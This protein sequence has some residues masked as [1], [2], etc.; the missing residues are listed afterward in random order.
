MIIYGDTARIAA[1]AFR[2]L[3]GIQSRLDPGQAPFVFVN[4]NN[5]RGGFFSCGL[6]K[7]Q[8]FCFS[9]IKK[10]S[11]KGNRVKY[12]VEDRRAVVIV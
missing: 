11:E 9:F 6:I 12:Y 2:S 8:K 1:H 7:L 3:S 5:S 4:K 10:I